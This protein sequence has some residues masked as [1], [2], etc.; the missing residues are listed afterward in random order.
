MTP[1]HGTSI[2]DY[3]SNV[4]EACLLKDVSNI[5]NISTFAPKEGEVRYHSDKCSMQVYS[6]TGKCWRDINIPVSEN[7]GYCETKGFI[8]KLSVQ[9][10]QDLYKRKDELIN[11][12][13]KLLLGQI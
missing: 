11:I 6:E 8:E 1:D 9:Q 10:L 5:G 2:F 13:E 7:D 3:K 4:V 12:I